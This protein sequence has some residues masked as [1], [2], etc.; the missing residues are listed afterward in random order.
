MQ[1][2]VKK[3]DVD[4]N[5]LEEAIKG[6]SFIKPPYCL[7]RASKAEIFYLGKDLASAESSYFHDLVM[8]EGATVL[9]VS[10]NK[11]D[12]LRQGEVFNFHAAVLL[13]TTDEG[14]TALEALERNRSGGALIF[15]DKVQG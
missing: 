7:T 12:A 1:A 10:K 5:Q 6:L 15:F 3:V 14:Q 4:V 13:T 9:V 11:P 8:I 2:T